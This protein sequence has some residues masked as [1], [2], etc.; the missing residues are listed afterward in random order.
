[1]LTHSSGFETNAL[2]LKLVDHCRKLRERYGNLGDAIAFGGDCAR[3]ISH[4]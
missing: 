2:A 3:K 1:M 4:M